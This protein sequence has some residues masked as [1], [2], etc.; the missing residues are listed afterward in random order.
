MKSIQ[1][2]GN[3]CRGKCPENEKKESFEKKRD[4]HA[5]KELRLSRAFP[6]LFKS[7]DRALLALLWYGGQKTVLNG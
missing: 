1:N 2:A 3:K 5:Q 7:S 4:R 6:R